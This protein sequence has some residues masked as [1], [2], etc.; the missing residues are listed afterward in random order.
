LIVAAQ[1]LLKSLGTYSGAVDGAVGRDTQAAIL[2][3]QLKYGL[4]FDP[5]VSPSLL[6]KLAEVVAAKGAK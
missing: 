5:S 6:A 4:E 1:H 3:F 2:D